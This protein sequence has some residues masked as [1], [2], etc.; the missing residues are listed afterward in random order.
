MQKS[1]LMYISTYVKILNMKINL[2][3]QKAGL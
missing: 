1:Y 3:W 2:Q